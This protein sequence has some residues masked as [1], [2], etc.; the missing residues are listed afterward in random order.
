MDHHIEI[1]R[2]TSCRETLCAGECGPAAGIL[3]LFHRS[4]L[5]ESKRLA[6]Q[7]LEMQFCYCA[8]ARTY[9]AGVGRHRYCFFWVMASS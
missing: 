3:R 6:S 4:I 8:D 2:D 1:S 7:R 5:M 9:Y